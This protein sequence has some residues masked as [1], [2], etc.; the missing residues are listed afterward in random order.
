MKE[1]YKTIVFKR[2]DSLEPFMIEAT[3]EIADHLN[4]K[5]LI[6]CSFVQ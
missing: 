6:L 2:T 5:G 4:L 3:R 1:N